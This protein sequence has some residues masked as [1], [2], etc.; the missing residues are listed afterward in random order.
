MT[1]RNR[2]V[3]PGCENRQRPMFRFSNPK[4]GLDRCR[5]WKLAV[6]NPSLVDHSYYHL[7]RTCYVCHKHFNAHDF[8]EGTT[9][10]KPNAVPSVD[11]STNGEGGK[12]TSPLDTEPTTPSKVSVIPDYLTPEKEAS[13]LLEQAGVSPRKRV[14]PSKGDISVK[15]AKI[16]MESL[17]MASGSGVVGG[18][19]ARLSG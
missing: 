3:V 7:S 17:E 9:K 5:K 11:L 10:L 12:R 13:C 19:W 8:Y 2:C 14:T 15:R 16:S 6:N 18:C 1:S 4:K